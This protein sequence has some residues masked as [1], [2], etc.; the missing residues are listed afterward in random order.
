MSEINIGNTKNDKTMIFNENGI[1]KNVAKKHRIF[2]TRI[3]IE[4]Q[5]KLSENIEKDATLLRKKAKTK[6]NGNKEHK[7][8]K[9]S[10]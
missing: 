2:E 9:Q 3:R 5:S 10:K 4:K 1:S 8:C 6:R 7:E